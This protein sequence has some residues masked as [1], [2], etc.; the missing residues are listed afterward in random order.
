MASSSSSSS[1]TA[2]PEFEFWNP[3]IPDPHILSADQL[4]SNGVLLPLN[5][6]PH[7]HHPSPRP[8]LISSSSS[9]SKR[10]L[11]IF[12]KSSSEKEKTKKDIPRSNSA[13]AELNINLWPFSR[14]RSAGSTTPT[15]KQKTPRKSTSAPC[16]R[17]NSRGESSAGRRWSAPSPGRP[18]VHVGRSS[19]VWQPRRHPGKVTATGGGG[20]GIRGININVDTCIGCR[21]LGNGTGGDRIRKDGNASLFNFRAFFS[22][23]VY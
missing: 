22:K 5:P 1:A 6:P 2:S 10:W 15:P 21:T 11:H 9:S 14:S 23:K 13:G 7:P 8:S 18:G 19:P 4:F 17:S 12:N 20:G 3:S 16:S